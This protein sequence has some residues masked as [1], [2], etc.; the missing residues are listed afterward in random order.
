METRQKVY[1]VV[2]AMLSEDGSQLSGALAKLDDSPE[3]IEVAEDLAEGLELCP[4]AQASVEEKAE[5]LVSLLP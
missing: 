2:D 3:A 4:L 5:G 1:D